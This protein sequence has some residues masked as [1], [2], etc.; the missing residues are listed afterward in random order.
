MRVLLV[1][2]DPRV[3][4]EMAL[5]ARGARRAVGGV[6]AEEPFEILQASDGLQ[7][8]ALAWQRRPD[9]V[10]ADEIMS[11]AGAFAVARE[12]KGADPPFGGQVVILL[13]RQVDAWL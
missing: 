10:V 3:R 2:R 8:I 11:R 13:E 1:S 9:V 7:G 4:E 5:V 12:L 6:R